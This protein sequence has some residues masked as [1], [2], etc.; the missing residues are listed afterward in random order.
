M[1]STVSYIIEFFAPLV[2][3]FLMARFLLQASKADFY[4]PISQGIVTITDP[5]LKP[6]RTIIPSFRRFDLSAIV[7]AWLLQAA[8]GYAI[9]AL[10][11][12]VFPGWPA[13]LVISLFGVLRVLL[14]IYWFMIIISI[15]SSWVAP[16][17]S[18]PALDLVRQILE[19]IMGPARRLLPPLGGLDFSPILAFLLIGLLSDRILPLLRNAILSAL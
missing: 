6:L 13:H 14:Q 16:T 15:I 10:N 9:T 8:L 3:F 7:C 17:T 1:S 12:D 11:N 19:P 2:A 4:N 18:H 5:L